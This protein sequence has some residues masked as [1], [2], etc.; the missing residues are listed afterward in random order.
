[1]SVVDIEAFLRKEGFG[2][3]LILSTNKGLLTHAQ[4]IHQKVGGEVVCAIK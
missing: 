2:R 3:I 4:A 1:M